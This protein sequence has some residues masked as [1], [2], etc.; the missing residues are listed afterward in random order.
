[1]F[2][3][4]R[5]RTNNSHMVL[6]QRYLIGYPNPPSREPFRVVARLRI[7]HNKDRIRIEVYLS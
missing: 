7:L 5:Q 6:H 2:E 4:D 3:K 1:M